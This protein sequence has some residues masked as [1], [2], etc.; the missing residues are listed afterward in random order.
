MT[1]NN[2][3]LQVTILQV[4]EL[5]EV[6]EIYLNLIIKDKKKSKIYK[7]NHQNIFFMNETFNFNSIN[8]KVLLIE[9]YDSLNNYLGKSK[10]NYSEINEFEQIDQVLEFEKGKIIIEIIAKDFGNKMKKIILKYGNKEGE[11]RFKQDGYITPITIKEAL[12][13]NLNQISF[14]KIISLYNSKQKIKLDSELN[15]FISEDIKDSQIYSIEIGDDDYLKLKKEEIENIQLEYNNLMNLNQISLD[16]MKNY[17]DILKKKEKDY[18]INLLSLKMTQTLDLNEMNELNLKLK[19]CE[20]YIDLEYDYKLKYL[21]SLEIDKSNTIIT[22]EDFLKL[23]AKLKLL[24][25]K[26]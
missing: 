21:Y 8:E 3:K 4:I 23:N 12:R 18:I 19:I 26:K 5:K 16:K 22:M 9:V 2:P 17:I 1:T 14:L 25:R 24:E 10:Y 15:I 7:K 6:D 13:L 20:K 11:L